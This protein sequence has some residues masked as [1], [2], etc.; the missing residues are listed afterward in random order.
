VSHLRPYLLTGGRVR[1]DADALEIEAQVVTTETGFL[2]M[3]TLEFE[4]RDIVELCQLPMAVAEVAA[5]LRL[6]LGVTRVLVSD[7][8]VLGHLTVRRPEIVFQRSSDIIQRVIQGLQS[9]D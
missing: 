4:Q 2:A 1:P 6:H 5:R 7:L 3:G 9:I 8:L